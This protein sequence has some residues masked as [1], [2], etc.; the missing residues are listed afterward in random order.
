MIKSLKILAA[1]IVLAMFAVGTVNA[2]M[3]GGKHDLKTN[4]GDLGNKTAG[5]TDLCRFCHTPHNGFSDAP[6]WWRTGPDTTTFTPYSSNTMNASMGQ[7]TG[8]SKGCLSCHDGV[9]AFDALAGDT[10]AEA[11]NNMNT[12][13]SGSSAI[14]GADL[15]ND[16]PI[17]INVDAGDTDIDTA[18]NIIAAGVPLYDNGAGADTFVECASCHEPHED[19]YDFFLR[20]DPSVGDLCESCHLK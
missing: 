5:G 8:V 18:A 7:P 17:G 15:S 4:A 9:T 13:Y 6:L 20:R 19:T 3:S 12:L 11:G 10:G 14:L 1:V 16:H 2:Q